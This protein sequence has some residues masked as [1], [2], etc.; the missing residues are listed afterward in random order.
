MAMSDPTARRLRPEPASSTIWWPGGWSRDSTDLGT[1][2]Q[3]LDEGPITV[4]CGFDPTA[5]SLHVGHLVPAPA[6]ASVPGLR[7]IVR[8]RSPVVPRG[9][10]ATPAVGPRNATCWTA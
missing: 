3:R 5:D 2:R 10:W 7:A 9:W 8:S 6:A 4:Y 1:L